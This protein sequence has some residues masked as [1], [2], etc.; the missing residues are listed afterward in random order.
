MKIPENPPSG[1]QA[2]PALTSTQKAWIVFLALGISITALDL[3]TKSWAFHVLQ[4][5][6][7]PHPETPHRWV[8][9]DQKVIV[10][11]DGLF[12]LE[13]SLNQG[14][15]S[16]WFSSHTKALALLSFAAIF[17][18]SGILWNYLRKAPSVEFAFVGSLGCILGGTAGNFYD[19]FVLGAVRDFIKWFIVIDGKEYVWP[20]FNIADSAICIGVG[21][22]VLHFYL[23]PRLTRAPAAES[24]G[25]TA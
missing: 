10:V 22:M 6:S 8:V 12:E 11:I 17:V 23:L 18:I 5:R 9:Y 20:N 3:W 2:A 13:A 15:F 24:D 14:A 7:G 19:R 1:H 21:L 25:R 16:G 4:V